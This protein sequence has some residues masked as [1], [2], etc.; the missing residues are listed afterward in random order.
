MNLATTNKKLHVLSFVTLIGTVKYYAGGKGELSN[1]E[2]T[3][4]LS[5]A[6]KFKNSKEA[7]KVNNTLEAYYYRQTIIEIAPDFWV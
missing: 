4:Q 6:V 7:E 5:K 2:Q 1:G 3:T